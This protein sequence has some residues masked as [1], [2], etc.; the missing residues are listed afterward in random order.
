MSL[1]GSLWMTVMLRGTAAADCLR[2]VAGKTWGSGWLS[3]DRA[4]GWGEG[5]GG[6]VQGGGGEDLGQGA[7]IHEQI[8]GQRWIAEQHAQQQ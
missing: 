7:A 8:V 6:L 2:R 3:R 5:G 4:A 1:L